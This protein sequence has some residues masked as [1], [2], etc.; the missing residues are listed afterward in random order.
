[1]RFN[2]GSTCLAKWVALGALIMAGCTTT[3]SQPSETTPD[4][5]EA[6]PFP[7]GPPANFYA[8]AM[9][10]HKPLGSIVGNPGA[11]LPR[12]TENRSNQFREL[13][14]YAA[15][16]DSYALLIWHK[17]A[18]VLEHYFAP[19]PNDTQAE[20]ASMHKTV[21]ALAIAAA[22]TDGDISSEHDRVGDYIEAWRDDP[23][24]DIKIIQLL[25]MASGTE[26]LSQQGGIESD[27]Y[28]FWM[29]GDEARETT[30]SRPLRDEPGTV[31]IYQEVV[32]QMLLMVLES[33]TKTPYE[34]YVS[35]RLWQRIG[36]DDAY[37]WRNEPDGFPRAGTAFLAQA[38]D[39]LRVGL[40]IK[41]RGDVAGQPLVAPEIIDRATT[42]SDTNPNYAWQM[43]RGAEYQQRRYYNADRTGASFAASAPYTV[44]DFTFLDGFGGQRV[45]VSQSE[46]LVIVR[47]GAMQ[48]QW[49]DAMLPNLAM[50]ALRNQAIKRTDLTMAYDDN[51]TTRARVYSPTDGCQQC[52]VVFFSHGA[53]LSHEGYVPLIRAWVDAGYVVVAPLH[54][55]SKSHPRRDDYTGLDWVRTRITDYEMLANAVTSKQ[56]SIDGVT[57]S[58]GLIAA[59]HSFGALTAQIAGGA[60]LETS[61][62]VTLS[63]SAPQPLGV[64]ALSPPGPIDNYINQ[65]GW[66]QLNRP[67]LTVTGTT[68]VVEPFA[69]E[70]SLHKAA[71]EVAPQGQ[72]YLL[73][74]NDMDHYFNGAFAR[75]TVNVFS[76]HKSVHWLNRQLIE[77]SNHLNDGTLPTPEQ[78]ANQSNELVIAESR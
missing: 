26:P 56:L 42:A 21:L 7:A 13:I 69:P 48:V 49:D 29:K 51:Y 40:L 74:F 39:W 34:Q 27:A 59:G 11:P 52:A 3:D 6:V 60:T 46:D 78:W 2:V 19:Y 25:N 53:G 44:D 14:Q 37:V 62:G 50:E 32:S 22:M 57:L 47:T 17:G 75:P 20:S 31:F 55:D 36:A 70:W 61:V 30:L 9:Q 18:I 68:D 24:G 33:A 12:R 66:R 23:R 15:D 65:N 35:E 63:E 28:R 77:F 54:V 4:N 67:S 45:Y 72:A 71:Y 41:N 58:G 1:M 8:T 5:T 43:W 38:K 64:I 16:Q 73:V 76:T 10:R